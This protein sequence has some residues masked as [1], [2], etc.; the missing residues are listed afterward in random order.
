[1][2]TTP[3]LR[4]LALWAWAAGLALW[5]P[6]IA[7]PVL[8]LPLQPLDLVTIAGWPLLAVF[9]RRLPPAL[10]PV[11][12]TGAGSVAIGWAMSG[13]E[14][15]ILI[16]TLGFAF[17]FVLLAAIAAG[18]ER[19]LAALLSAFLAG[20]F[21]SALLFFAQ[22]LLGAEA[23]DFR[24]NPAFRLPPH[25]GRGFALF[26]EV[27]TY[28]AHAVIAIAAALV[29]ALHPATGRARRMR[30]TGLATLLLLA[31]LFTRSTSV[32]VLLPLVVTLALSRTT[33]ASLNMLVLVALLAILMALL[34]VV[35]VQSFYAERLASEAAQR[36]ASMRLASIVGGLTPLFSGEPFGVG[37]GENREIRYRAFEVARSL[38]LSFGKLPEG[39]NAQIVGRIFEEGWPAVLHFGLAV[40]VLGRALRAATAPA[41]T[42]VACLAAASFAAA[43]TTL[44]YRGLYT[45]WLWLGVP[46]G[47]LL[48]HGRARRLPAR[49]FA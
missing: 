29:L 5:A 37:I 33:R 38:G 28:A 4:A 49:G 35:F 9:A 31:L 21:L 12:L 19:A 46:A 13:G 48:R 24:N 36:S 25:Y 7:V 23:L 11:L 22:I 15:L 16:W 27:S 26:P 45:T 8:G 43:A 39:V 1:M 6:A 41:T 18:E 17:P 32:V 47:L 34:L 3:E 14:P 30:M 2:H 40:L 42:A 20:A 10:L 44:G